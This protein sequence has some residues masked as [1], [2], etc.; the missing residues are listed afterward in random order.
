[1]VFVKRISKCEANYINIFLFH[2]GNSMRQ[3]LV[4]IHNN[5]VVEEIH[6]L[7]AENVKF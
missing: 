2:Y 1:M 7:N 4:D 6:F 3:T 5:N